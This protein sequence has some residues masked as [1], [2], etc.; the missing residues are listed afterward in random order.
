MKQL[1]LIGLLLPATAFG[2][3]GQVVEKVRVI[4]A[5]RWASTYVGV[6]E[7][8]M[9]AVAWVE[10]SHRTTLPVKKDGSTPSYGVFQI[11]LETARWVDK[12]YHHKHKATPTRLL[13]VDDNALYACKYMKL[14]LKRYGNWQ[15]AVD[16]YNKGHVVSEE[17]GY[18]QKVK[19][20]LEVQFVK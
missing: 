5:I 20:A 16:A 6:P 12:V 8:L 18:V 13:T 9:I 11:K 7:D 4:N 17:S 15:M 14:L 10:S 3:V 1:I 2:K 19:Q